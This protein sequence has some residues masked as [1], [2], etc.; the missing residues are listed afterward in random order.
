M[1]IYKK[2]ILVL[3]FCKRI[4]LTWWR[5]GKDRMN[6]FE[7]QFEE[8]VLTRYSIIYSKIEN[9]EE[10]KKISNEIMK[11]YVEI[12]EKLKEIG[13]EDV[14]EEITILL[15]LANELNDITFKDLY[16]FAFSDGLYFRD[17][18]RIENI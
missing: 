14:M 8:F 18:Y 6:E 13:E 10:Y 4:P 15:D 16:K 1:R 11:K 3:F 2:Y 5:G 17:N 12:L 7:N 9:K